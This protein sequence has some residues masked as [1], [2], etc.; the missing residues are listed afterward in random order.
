MQDTIQINQSINAKHR[1]PGIPLDAD[2]VLIVIGSIAA[3]VAIFY[4]MTNSGFGFRT[5]IAPGAIL[6]LIAC[7]YVF[8]LR[9]GNPPAYATDFVA[10]ELLG[11][12]SWEPDFKAIE[13]FEK[14]LTQ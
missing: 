11:K 2:N 8:L 6:F 5:G 14:N 4:G 12:K 3:G 1:I 9:Q 7:A 13:Q 10:T